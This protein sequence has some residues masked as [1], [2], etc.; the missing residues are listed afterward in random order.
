MHQYSI[1]GGVARNGSFCGYPLARA[2]HIAA[3]GCERASGVEQLVR[4]VQD[5]V[6][7]MRIGSKSEPGQGNR[8][9]EC[10][11]ACFVEEETDKNQLGSNRF[12][13]DRCQVLLPGKI[14]NDVCHPETTVV[15]PVI[16]FADSK[17]TAIVPPRFW[18][19]AT[20]AS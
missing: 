18:I 20:F 19:F 16:V 5:V 17:H 8:P 7:L 11:G 15:A 10:R 3:T 4:P 12:S 1:C 13:D 9:G 14:T 2:T 6:K